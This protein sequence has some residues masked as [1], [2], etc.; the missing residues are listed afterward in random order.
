M[1][2]LIHEGKHWLVERAEKIR[3]IAE[4]M[5]D[6]EIRRQMHGI[7]DSYLR[8]AQHTVRDRLKEKYRISK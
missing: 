4:R 8:L 7:A 1:A 5:T 2:S 3:T 6:P